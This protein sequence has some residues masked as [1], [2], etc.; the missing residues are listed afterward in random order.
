M[1]PSM[2]KKAHSQK[3]FHIIELVA[4]PA[5]LVVYLS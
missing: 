5:G 1:N 3:I 2:A 4:N